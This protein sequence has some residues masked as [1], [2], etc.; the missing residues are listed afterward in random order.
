[1]I[2]FALFSLV[3]FC[4]RLCTAHN[5][6]TYEE[7]IFTI[8]ALFYFLLLLYNAMTLCRNSSTRT[9]TNGPYNILVIPGANNIAI[10]STVSGLDDWVFKV[11][12]CLCI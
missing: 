11:G 10:I 8:F 4:F 1:M 6:L 2:F 9:I 3:P 7:G 12:I 5:P